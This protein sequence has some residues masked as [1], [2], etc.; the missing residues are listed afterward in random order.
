MEDHTAP[1]PDILTRVT[2]KRPGEETGL[3]IDGLQGRGSGKCLEGV[4]SAQ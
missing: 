3:G 2:E 1:K 4:G